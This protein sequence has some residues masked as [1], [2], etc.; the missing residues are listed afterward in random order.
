MKKQITHVSVHQSSKVFALLYFIIAA[1]FA[2]PMGI[3]TVMRHE[4]SD[5]WVWVAIPFIYMILT[6][7]VMAILFFL[8]NRVAAYFGGVEY[9]T[10]EK[11]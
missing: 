5:A 11:E 6:Y 7:I 1:L 8:Y 9:E 10:V 4:Y 2:I 3:L